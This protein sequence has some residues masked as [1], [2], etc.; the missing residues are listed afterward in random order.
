MTSDLDDLLSEW[1]APAPSMA[2]HATVIA[3][4]PAPRAPSLLLRGWTWATAGGVAAAACAA[5]LAAGVWLAPAQP[6]ATDEAA[7]VSSL[8]SPYDPA[9]D[10]PEPGSLG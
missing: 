7:A 1:R 4:A 3:A 5:G 9:G 2:L 8:L 10:L 6:S